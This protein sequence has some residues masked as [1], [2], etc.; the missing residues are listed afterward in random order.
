M[1]YLFL[2]IIIAL[3]VLWMMKDPKDLREEYKGKT[4]EQKAVIRYFRREGCLARTMK[5]EEYDEIVTRI[6]NSQNFKQKAL[7]KFGLDEDQVKEIPPVNFNGYVYNRDKAYV[8]KGKDELFR[9][10]RYQITWLFFGD[11][12]VYFYQYTFNTDENTK[13]ETADEYFYKDITNFSHATT[14]DEYY[15]Y[16]KHGEKHIENVDNTK[17]QIVVPGDKMWAAM[18][19]N[20]QNENVVKAMKNKLR[21]KKGM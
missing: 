19:Q 2:L 11:T 14:T 15:R 21:E 9:S 20:E 12:Q 8:K 18:E 13:S 10:S 7:D 1:L 16:D 6:A 4:A 3:V 5:D 17:F